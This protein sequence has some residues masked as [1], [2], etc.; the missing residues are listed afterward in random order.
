MTPALQRWVAITLVIAAAAYLSWRA[1]RARRAVAAP[2]QSARCGP[3]C[4]CGS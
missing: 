2:R 3:G 4:G 1:W